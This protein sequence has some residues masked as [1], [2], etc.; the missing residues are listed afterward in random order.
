M[1]SYIWLERQRWGVITSRC[2]KYVP[3]CVC[4]TFV[5]FP[6]SPFQ[7]SVR[8]I[9]A[10]NVTFTA[11]QFYKLTFAKNYGSGDNIQAQHLSNIDDND[12]H[13]HCNHC[14]CKSVHHCHP[15][16]TLLEHCLQ[17]ILSHS[18]VEEQCAVLLSAPTLPLF[19]R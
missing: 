3:V 16:E 8:G 17:A 12:L 15:Q 14:E 10:T 5:T 6:P 7:D 1:T 2:Q 19:S 9:S 18:T 4:V 11:S 13:R